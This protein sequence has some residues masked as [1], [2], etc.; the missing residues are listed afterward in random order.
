MEINIY[1]T[2]KKAVTSDYLQYAYKKNC[3]IKSKFTVCMVPEFAKV[4]EQSTDFHF[5][6][7]EQ[8]FANVEQQLKGVTDAQRKLVTEDGDKVSM[9][10]SNSSSSGETQV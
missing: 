10:S 8:Q 1:F 5:P 6:N 2:K 7:L 9:K 3:P 4:C